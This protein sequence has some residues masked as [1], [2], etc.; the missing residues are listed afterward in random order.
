[1]TAPSEWPRNGPAAYRATT[2]EDKSPRE[3]NP[4]VEG[5]LVASPQVVKSGPRT[6]SRWRHGFEPRWDYKEKRR[7]EALSS[8]QGARLSWNFTSDV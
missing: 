5:H 3:P 8:L 1:M 2:Q 6:L 7:S 4:Q